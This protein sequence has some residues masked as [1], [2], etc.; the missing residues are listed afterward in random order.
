MEGFIGALQAGVAG[1][2]RTLGGLT[3]ELPTF[4]PVYADLVGEAGGPSRPVPPAPPAN[5]AGGNS[6]YLTSIN[7]VGKSDVETLSDEVTRLA[8]LGVL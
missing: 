3:G 2:R 6:I 1:V 4:V 7:P 5:G 8:E